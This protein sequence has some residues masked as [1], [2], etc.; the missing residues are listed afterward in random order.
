MFIGQ[1]QMS[2]KKK[3][4]QRDSQD[5]NFYKPS[6]NHH[7]MTGFNYNEFREHLDTE[8]SFEAMEYYERFFP[9]NSASTMVERRAV[10]NWLEMNYSHL[11]IKVR[12]GPNGKPNLNYSIDT[13]CQEVAMK[14]ELARLQS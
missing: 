2:S 13:F 11:G 9:R 12:P 10:L 3:I 1:R 6:G 8:G 4:P 7:K 5:N 14:R